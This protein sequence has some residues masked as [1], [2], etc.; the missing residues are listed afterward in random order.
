[1]AALL[2]TGVNWRGVTKVGRS[3]EDVN[4]ALSLR[5]EVGI[6]R[7]AQTPTGGRLQCWT[8]AR[9][10]EEVMQSALSSV[11]ATL[12]CFIRGRRHIEQAHREIF[13]G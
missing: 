12:G 7:D 4:W 6:R 10:R 13:P 8:L 9:G 5:A 11:S 3:F 1:M 2:D